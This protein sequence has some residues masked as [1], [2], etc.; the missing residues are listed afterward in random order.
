VVI[1]LVDIGNTSSEFVV[2]DGSAVV[3]KWRM[4]TNPLYTADQYFVWVSRLCEQAGLSLL[5]LGAIVISEVVQAVGQI[6]EEFC[7][8]YLHIKPI[9]VDVAKCNF[10]MDF[11]VSDIGS[12]GADRLVNASVGRYLFGNNIIV[13]DF[14]TATT[15]DVVDRNGVYLGGVISSGL[16]MIRDVLADKTAKL[17]HVDLM[18][19]EV[20]VGGDTVMAMRSGIYW[21]YL[22]SVA[23]ICK[24]IQREMSKKY[25]QEGED[26][27][28]RVVCTGG[29]ASGLV[30]DMDFI[31][32]YEPELW[33]K[34][35]FYIY[36]ING[37]NSAVSSRI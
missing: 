19:P 32:F 17:P 23:E 5:D 18:R 3:V 9:I 26:S 7:D 33:I 35:L 11:A 14:G 36:Q 16:A 22:G 28:L 10:A 1:L 6:L 34:G 21:G 12:V 13:I 31:D 37:G 25:K 4:G 20:V 24:Q 30:S 27:R 15:F 2:H 8:K 29:Y